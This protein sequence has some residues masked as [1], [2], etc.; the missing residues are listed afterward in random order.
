MPTVE[1]FR[2]KIRKI[3]LYMTK[4]YRSK[5]LIDEHFTIISNNCWGG[6]IYQSYGVKYQTPTIG[7]FIMPA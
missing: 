1:G 3:Y 2:L 6:T 7:M 5:K 4:K